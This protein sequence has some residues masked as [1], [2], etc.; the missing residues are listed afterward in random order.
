MRSSQSATDPL[1]PGPAGLR[2]SR[3]ALR[4]RFPENSLLAFAAALELGAGI[5]CDLRLTADDQILVFHD[6]DALAA[7]RQPAAHRPVDARRARPAAGRRPSDPDARTACSRWSAAACRC[8]SKSRSTAIS[9]AGSRRCAP[10]STAMTGRFGVMSFDPRLPRL[11]QDQ[12]CRQSGAGWSSRDRLPPLKRRLALWLADPD[13]LAVERG[14]ARQAVGRARPPANAGLQLDDPHPRAARDKPRFTPTRSSGKPMADRE[15]ELIARI[16]PGV[17]RDRRRRL[18]RARRRGDP[19]LSH[20]FLAA[21]EDLGQR[22]PRHRLDARCRSWSRTRPA[23]LAA[24][25]GLS[26]EPQPGRI[27]VRPRL[28]RRVGARRRALLSQAAGRGAVHAGARAAA[29]RRQPAA[30]ARRARSGDACRTS[31]SSAHI[32]F[33]DEAGAAECER[34]GWLIRDGIQY[35]WL[36][37]GYRQLRRFPRRAVQPQAQGDPQGTRGGPRRARD[38]SRCAAPRSARPTGTRCGISTRTPA[39]ANGASPI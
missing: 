21:L 8:C 14:G 22:R 6:A 3:A 35:H 33:I 20:A 38:S 1:D 28:G 29:A 9:G 26:Q 34:R 12:C 4:R 27:C 11:A 7:V 23:P 17:A 36:N 37:R 18:G 19:F 32:T 24:A 31:L 5:E 10:R 15:T 13:F 2:P 25:P 39:A 16:A 30:A